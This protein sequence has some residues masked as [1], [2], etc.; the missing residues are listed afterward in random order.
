LFNAL[1]PELSSANRITGS[2]S[3][4]ARLICV[5]RNDAPYNPTEHSREHS[6]ELFHELFCELF[7]E[8]S[9]PRGANQRC[10]P[11]RHFENTTLV[12]CRTT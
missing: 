3:D 10:E 5:G 2:P 1:R 11:K 8:L 6:H 4:A 9:H 7:H 12:S